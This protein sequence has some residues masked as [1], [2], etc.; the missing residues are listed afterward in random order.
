MITFRHPSD[1][2]TEL[3]SIGSLWTFLKRASTY[4]V[5]EIGF[6]DALISN[7]NEFVEEVKGSVR[8]IEDFALGDYLGLAESHSGVRSHFKK[9]FAVHLI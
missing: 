8:I 3:Y 9:G 7:D 2:L 1:S 4:S 5:H 6:A